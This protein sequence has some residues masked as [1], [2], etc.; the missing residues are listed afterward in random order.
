MSH[1]LQQDV[2]LLYSGRLVGHVFI[3]AG[4]QKSQLL[5]TLQAVVL[6][7]TVEERFPGVFAVSHAELVKALYLLPGV[8]Q[9]EPGLDQGRGLVEVADMGTAEGHIGVEICI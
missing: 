2:V 9:P 7:E 1:L 5:E 4:T 8:E 6:G 3:L